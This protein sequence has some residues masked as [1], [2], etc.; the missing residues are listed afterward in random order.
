M[1]QANEIIMLYNNQKYD[2]ACSM[3][4]SSGT[5]TEKF[6]L[7]SLCKFMCKF[8]SAYLPHRQLCFKKITTTTTAFLISNTVVSNPY[9]NSGAFNPLSFAPLT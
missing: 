8:E 1:T 5:C 3:H 6:V 9:G 7:S 4:T 2:C